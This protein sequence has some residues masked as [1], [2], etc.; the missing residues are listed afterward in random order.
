MKQVSSIFTAKDVGITRRMLNFWD[1][2]GMLKY[3]APNQ[4]HNYGEYGWRRFTLEEVVNI[5]VAN[6]LRK[7]GF[8]HKLIKQIICTK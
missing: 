7:L 3:L 4:Q 8:E 1:K 5:Q 2:D 6:K